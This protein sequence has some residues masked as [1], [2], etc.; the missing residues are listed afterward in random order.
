MG[1]DCSFEAV[2]LDVTLLQALKALKKG[3]AATLLGIFE[4]PDVV[5]PA[6]L[7]IQREISLA[8]SQ[9]YCWDFQDGLTLLENGAVDLKRLITH[10]FPLEELQ[11]GFEL[12]C[13]PKTASIKVVINME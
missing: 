9:G 6:N 1:V 12:L 8:G 5:I 7:F 3:G 2:G 10:R 11:Q 13:N 4:N